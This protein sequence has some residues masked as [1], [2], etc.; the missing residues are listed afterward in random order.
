MSQTQTQGFQVTDQTQ[1][2]T[3][4]GIESIPDVESIDLTNINV[5]NRYPI[6]DAFK[7]VIRYVVNK[8]YTGKGYKPCEIL[9]RQA[10]DGE[11]Q[12]RVFRT[13]PVKHLYKIIFNDKY[14]LLLTYMPH[15]RKRCYSDNCEK[16]NSYTVIG[17]LIG[18]MSNDKLFI[19]QVVNDFR[20]ADGYESLPPDK[21]VLLDYRPSINELHDYFFSPLGYHHDIELDPDVVNALNSGNWTIVRVQGDITLMIEETNIPVIITNRII[22][23]LQRIALLY[24]ARRIQELLLDYGITSAINNV[25][26]EIPMWKIPRDHDRRIEFENKLLEFIRDLLRQDGT[27]Y[28]LFGELPIRVEL[29]W[30]GENNVIRISADIPFNY[31]FTDT[32]FYK[33]IHELVTKE[34]L[35][36]KDKYTIRFGRHEINYIGY[37]QHLSI[38]YDHDIIG[39]IMINVDFAE[40]E[41][42]ANE[43]LLTHPEHEAFYWKWD[44][45]RHIT[46]GN[47]TNMSVN[48]ENYF[49]LNMAL[50]R[51]ENAKKAQKT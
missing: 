4:A 19:H 8:K 9:L 1:T 6:P 49:A 5:I 45:P 24:T 46:V 31:P 13:I 28:S 40:N 25:T 34:F 16:I 23:Q 26:V 21:D 37:P 43:V 27:V 41:F 33:E 32:P 42:I 30:R 20:W 48:R 7:C 47:V 39:R 12:F 10:F 51:W 2:V 36:R 11:I 38:I 22:N 14:V 50:K 18:L 15:Y 35:S 44:V 17:F 29:P 3:Q